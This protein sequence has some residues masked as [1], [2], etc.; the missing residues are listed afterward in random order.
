[1]SAWIE[2]DPDYTEQI[3]SICDKIKELTDIVELMNKQS[4]KLIMEIQGLRLR[5]ETAVRRLDDM[6]LSLDINN[7]RVDEIWGKGFDHHLRLLKL[8][9]AQ[10]KP[11]FLALY[12]TDCMTMSIQEASEAHFARIKEY[13]KEHGKLWVNKE[14]AK[15]DN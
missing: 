14:E 15:N 5:E 9:E 6:K 1:M 8:E 12:Q 3:D 13:E 10:E 11:G 2:P 7:R 4:E